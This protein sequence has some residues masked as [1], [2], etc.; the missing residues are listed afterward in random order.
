M[1]KT[2][3]HQVKKNNLSIKI[4]VTTKLLVIS[5]FSPGIP[6]LRL[7]KRKSQSHNFPVEKD[8]PSTKRWTMS[9]EL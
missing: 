2:V 4:K 9:G 7:N 3:T 8:M 5:H 1:I 6:N